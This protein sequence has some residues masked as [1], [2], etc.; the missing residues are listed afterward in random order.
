MSEKNDIY[1]PFFG[2]QKP[3]IPSGYLM[4]G[5]RTKKESH[6]VVDSV[7]FVSFYSVLNKT[8]SLESLLLLY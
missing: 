6:P 4:A 7:I 5:T 2:F 8:F 1:S 3:L